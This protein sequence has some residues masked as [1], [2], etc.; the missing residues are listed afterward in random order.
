MHLR[1]LI[2]AATALATASGPVLA[3]AADSAAATDAPAPA[4]AVAAPDAGVVP[5]DQLSP[6]Y[7][8]QDELERGLWMQVDEAERKLK[9]SQLI[10]KDPALNTYVR[11]VLCRTIGQDECRNVRLYI[12]HTPHFNASMAPNGV[13][14]VWSGLLLRTQ[15]EAQ[16]AAVLGHEYIHFKNRHSVQLFREAKKKSGAAAWLAMTG[17][18]LIF[19]I[20]MI[21]DFF[22]FSREME[23]EADLGGL[24]LMQRAGYDPREAAVIWEQLRDEMDATAAERGTKSRKDKNGGLFGSHPPTAERVVYLREHAAGMAGGAQGERGLGSYR[25]AM[26][27]YWPVFVDD[28]LKMSDFGASAFLLDSIG[29]ANG[30]SSWLSYAYGELNRRR[31]GPD[32]LEKAVGY[33]TDAIGEGGDLPEIWR[34]R[35]LALLKLGRG[36]EAHADLEEY[37]ARAPEAPD[38]AMIAMV[39]GG[40]Q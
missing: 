20:G 36:A 25:V 30:S 9:A 29:K 33:Y 19:A 17:V 13:M 16:L 27:K 32:D 21:G 7:Q 24:E 3:Q 28:Q 31:A 26:A 18:G 11:G 38:H 12:M 34:G 8:P 15:D 2:L 5:E 4:V 14:Q 6:L 1:N 10:I 39:S 35:G 22:K 23:K 37:L 40:I